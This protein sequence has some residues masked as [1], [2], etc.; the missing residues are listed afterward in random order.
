MSSPLPS[1]VGS[2]GV[3]SDQVIKF[4]AKS[5]SI[6]M[7]FCSLHYTHLPIPCNV[8]VEVSRERGPPGIP[9]WNSRACARLVGRSPLWWHPGYVL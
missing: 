2:G 1:A 5:V 4:K 9:L 7:L 6:D 8:H 3:S